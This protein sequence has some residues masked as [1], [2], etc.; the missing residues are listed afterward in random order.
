MASLDL[1]PG[2]SNGASWQHTSHRAC[3]SPASFGTGTQPVMHAAQAPVVVAWPTG[4]C[5]QSLWLSFGCL[6]AGHTCSRQA[7]TINAHMR[8]R[9]NMC[10]RCTDSSN[11]ARDKHTS[12]RLPPATGVLPASHCW[13][14]PVDVAQPAAQA[15]QPLWLSFASVPGPHLLR[16]KR[17]LPSAS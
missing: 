6:P 15:M 12:H 11:G 5:T 9:R 13:Q 4:H 14:R 16:Y 8:L 2:S 10:Y 17:T 7:S 3:A 1:I